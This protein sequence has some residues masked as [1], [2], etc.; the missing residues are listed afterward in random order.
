MKD[1]QL[2]LCAVALPA[3]QAKHALQPVG[4]LVLDQEVD[5]ESALGALVERQPR[6]TPSHQG[7][8]LLGG[9]APRTGGVSSA[10]V[11]VTQTVYEPPKAAG[12]V[13]K[14]INME[15]RLIIHRFSSWHCN[16]PS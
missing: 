13:N 5:S 15:L 1:L 11:S 12:A 8:E 14:A 2:R 4:R 9:P 10:E 7:T 3:C 6:S 16:T